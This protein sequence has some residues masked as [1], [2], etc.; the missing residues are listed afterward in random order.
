[1]AGPRRTGKTSLMK[2]LIEKNY[3]H[4]GKNSIYLRLDEHLIRKAVEDLGLREILSNTIEKV[5]LNEPLIIVIDEASA[6][7]G[8]DVHIKN[9]ID[10]FTSEGK[11]FLL[12]VT[13]SLGLRLIQGSTNILAR[14]GDIPYLGNIANPATILPYKFSEYAEALKLISQY[15]RFLELLKRVER[16]EILL[17]LAKPNVLDS[18]VQRLKILYD[19]FQAALQALFNDYYLVSGGFPLILYE[20]IIRGDFKKLDKKWYDEIGGSLL[21]DLKYTNLREDIVRCFLEYLTETNKMSPSLDLNKLENYIRAKANLSKKDLER[22]RIEDY[23]EY[24]CNTFT[25]VK[26]TEIAQIKEITEITR[27]IKL[28]ITDPF[29]FHSIMLKDY[30]DPLIESKKFLEN[31]SQM[32]ILVEHVVCGHFLRLTTRPTL[33]YHIYRQQDKTLGEIDCICHYKHTYIPIE[34][35]YTENEQILRNTANITNSILNNLEIKSRPIIVSKS[36]FEIQPDSA[37]IP[38]NTFLLLF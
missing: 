24:F 5:G 23:I 9:V 29:I 12:M 32:G 31:P 20:L 13:G 16:Q 2:K 28:F 21:Q 17:N 37:I 11:K 30:S 25:M 18:K 7:D 26:A 6:L 27:E 34:V 1:M 15:V 38:A 35:K 14:R 36:M 33:Y 19:K 4:I 3:Q 8:W 22:F 10:S